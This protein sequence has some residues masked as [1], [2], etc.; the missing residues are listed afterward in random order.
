MQG[1]DF[2]SVVEPALADV[3]EPRAI[4]KFFSHCR[5]SE[6]VPHDFL[7]WFEGQG[8]GVFIASPKKLRKR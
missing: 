5:G 3:S 7:N 8:H 4:P 2:V 6:A 1:F